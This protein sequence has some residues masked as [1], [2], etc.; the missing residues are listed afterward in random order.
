MNGTRTQICAYG[1]LE[2][3]LDF[4]LEASPDLKT[5]SDR[6]HLL[7]LIT[8]CETDGRDAT[9]EPVSYTKMNSFMHAI[10]LAAVGAVIGRLQYGSVSPSWAI[11]DRSGELARA[12]FT[13]DA[14]IG[15]GEDS[16]DED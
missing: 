11:V 8:G 9:K 2:F 12:V 1:R 10:D 7:A 13:D 5:Q 16:D 14:L 15:L 6:R 3:I 4:V